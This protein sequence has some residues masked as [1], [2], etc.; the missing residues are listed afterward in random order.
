[1][2]G[3]HVDHTDPGASLEP[4]VTGPPAWSWHYD[5]VRSLLAAKT[6]VA[7]AYRDS[8]AKG[9]T[10]PATPR[11]KTFTWPSGS[12]FLMQVAKHPRQGASEPLSLHP[13]AA[14]N[15]LVALPV[16]ADLALSL[17]MRQ[18]DSEGSST[19]QPPL[20]GWGAG[21]LDSGAATSVGGPLVPP[22]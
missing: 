19:M 10:N 18:G 13:V 4:F 6:T 15:P 7:G 17:S 20:L 3:M 16:C 2:A 12:S 5:Y 11:A 8:E 1:L 21:R 9:A 14:A 22:N